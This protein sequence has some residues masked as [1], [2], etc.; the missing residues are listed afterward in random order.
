[1]FKE[2]ADMWRRREA[3]IA[4]TLGLALLAGC[5]KPAAKTQVVSQEAAAAESLGGPMVAERGCVN[6]PQDM[7]GPAGAVCTFLEAVRTGDDQ[8]T[9]AM[10]VSAGR[11][12][13]KELKIPVTPHGS[14]TACFELGPVE[15]VSE[16]LARVA[17]KW[18]DLDSEGQRHTDEMTW[19][20]LKEA[21]GW[22]I[23]GLAATV[24]DGEPPLLLDFRDPQEVVEK[25]ETLRQEVARRVAKEAEQ[26]QTSNDAG[27]PIQR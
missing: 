22:R 7:D 3:W 1:L 19:A 4:L 23:A 25:L 5:G 18:T 13:I 10:F 8:K 2:D 11:E 12:K 15:Q 21:E 26:S 27:P 6:P 20:V 16:E 14:D 9:E 17:C 24:F